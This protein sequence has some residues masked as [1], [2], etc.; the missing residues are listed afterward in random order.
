MKPLRGAR[1]LQVAPFRKPGAARFF[2]VNRY[3]S[4]AYRAGVRSVDIPGGHKRLGS[5]CVHN[6]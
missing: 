3:V 2:P 4:I 1:T 6:S 5:L